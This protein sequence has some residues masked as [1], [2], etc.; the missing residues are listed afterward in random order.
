MFQKL[1]IVL[2]VFLFIVSCEKEITY[3]LKDVPADFV[4]LA[5]P[6]DGN[7]YQ[8]HI[9]PFP[10]PANFEREWYL[11]LPIGNK[12]KIYV[13]EMEVKMRPG[14]HHFIA[15]PFRDEN[16]PSNPKVGVIRDQNLASGR[17]NILS[18][19]NMNGFILEST[20]PEYSIKIP[21]NYGIPFEA[22]AT[23]DF[24]AHYF[25]KTQKTLFGEAYFNLYTKPRSQITGELKEVIIDNHDKLTLPP[26]KVTVIETIYT[27]EEMTRYLVLTSHNHK[28]GQKFEMYGVGGK[29]DGKLLY[30][31]TDY[32]HPVINYYN[33]GPLTFEKGDKIKMVVTYNN[34]TNRT[35]TFGVTSEDEMGIAFGYSIK[36]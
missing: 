24:N 5:K 19:T 23:L 8:V 3:D 25:N 22:G 36:N 12:E 21:L 26:N 7:G 10:V 13:T 4:P 15:Y 1:S 31:S 20:A 29:N 17:L 35:I 9:K 34:T 27:F 30:T 14:S 33:S 11:R 18:N 16:D 28:A 2:A 6:A 32:V